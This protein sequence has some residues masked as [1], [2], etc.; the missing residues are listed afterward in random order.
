IIILVVLGGGFLL[1]KG[2]GQGKQTEVYRFGA[3]DRGTV[4]TVVTATGTA[5]AVTTVQVGSQVSGTI[6]EIHVDFNSP[7]CKGQIVARLDPTFLQAAV[8]E[9]E[10]NLERA[11]ASLSQAERDLERVKDLFAKNLA[12]QADF[13][14][15][16][17]AVDLAKAGVAQVEAQ[18]ERSRV[19][20]AYSVITSPIDGVVISRDVDVGQTVAASLQA[21]TLFTIA[22]DLSEMQIETYIDEADIGGLREGMEATFTVDS[23]PEQEFHGTIQQIRY[24]AKQ[25]QN[26]V[27]YP[28]ILTVKNPELKLRPGMTANVTVVTARRDNVLRIPATALRFR[29]PENASNKSGQLAKNAPSDGGEKAASREKAIAKDTGPS[30]E[31]SPRNEIT[32]YVKG[33]NGQPEPRRLAVGL[34]DGSFVEIL[35]GD[36]KEGD[37]VI[38]GMAGT[39]SVGAKTMPGFGGRPPGRR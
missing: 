8:A 31:A 12:A 35:S 2:S 24:A 29:P 17:T 10:A 28:V 14:N 3:V 30:G 4:Q 39:S 20:L 37:S 21:P 38:I 36:L 9:A 19:N 18:R 32:V 1:L 13:D 26:V 25:E 6:R 5:S 11:K 22:Q 16:L 15:A 34:N 27:T 23:Y 7:V 33:K